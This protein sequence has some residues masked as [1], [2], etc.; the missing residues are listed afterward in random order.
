MV[1]VFEKVQ[2]KSLQRAKIT[3]FFEQKLC[4]IKAILGKEGKKV[5]YI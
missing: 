5:S 2:A 1:H 4:N 3:C